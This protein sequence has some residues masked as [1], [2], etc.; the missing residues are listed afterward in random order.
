MAA[1]G[2][3]VDL[4]ASIGRIAIRPTRFGGTVI[5]VVVDQPEN[6]AYDQLWA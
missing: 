6:F 1:P 2:A 3:G 4:L 5:R